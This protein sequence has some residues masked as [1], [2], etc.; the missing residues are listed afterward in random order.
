MVL[1]TGLALGAC[2]FALDGVPDRYHAAKRGPPPPCE[3]SAAAPIVDG[4]VAATMI[5][6]LVTTS[7]DACRDADDYNGCRLGKGFA[8]LLYGPPAVGYGFAAL[9]GAGK[10]MRC[11]AVT[12]EYAALQR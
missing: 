2:S 5:A 8:K 4:L 1:V 9:I 11:R 3:T 7:R 6:L 10:V 12:R